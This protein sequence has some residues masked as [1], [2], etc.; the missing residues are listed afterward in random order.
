[1]LGPR[2]A[3]VRDRKVGVIPGFL[4]PLNKQLK[5]GNP[6]KHA[7]IAAVQVHELLEAVGEHIGC[8]L[9]AER[10]QEALEVLH[11]FVRVHQAFFVKRPFV[12]CR[13]PFQPISQSW[14]SLVAVQLSD[15]TPVIDR[16]LVGKSAAS[17]VRRRRYFGAQ[18]LES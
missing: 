9:H 6:T 5:L 11:S 1:M 14:S 3:R 13:F 12:I 16:I 15:I 8:A 2:F 10:P 18:L 4:H 17:P 7:S